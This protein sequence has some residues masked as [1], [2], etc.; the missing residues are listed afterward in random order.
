MLFGQMSCV[1]YSFGQ[2]VKFVHRGEHKAMN[3]AGHQVDL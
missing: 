2:M 1:S 3:P